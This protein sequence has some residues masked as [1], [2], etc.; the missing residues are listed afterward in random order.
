MTRIWL[1]VFGV[2]II[3]VLT[4]FGHN[5]QAGGIILY[6]LGT[7][8]VGRAAAGWAARA[9]DGATLFTNPAGMSRLSGNNLLVGGQLIYGNFGF[10]P[11]ENTTV[12]GNDGGN[13]VGWL[14]GGSVFYTHEFS[15][16]WSAGLGVFSYFGLAAEYDPALPLERVPS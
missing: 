9:D 6:E 11:N 2:C 10:K 12:Q 15:P 13:P 1:T 7:P 3:L 16:R 14:P 5:A 4:G 8:D